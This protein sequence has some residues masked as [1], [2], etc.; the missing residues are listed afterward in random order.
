MKKLI[1]ILSVLFCTQAWSEG[2]VFQKTADVPMDVAYKR[3]YQQLEENRFYVVFEPNIGSNIS[4]FAE[5]WGEDYNRNGLTGIRSMVFC[6]GWYANAVGNA[7]PSMLAL[8]PLHVTLTE[9][10]GKTTVLF[11]R[12]TV[13]AAGSPALEVASEI[14]SQVIN[15]LEQA[16]LMPV[17]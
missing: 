4:G 13:I 8:C 10:G 1:V 9:K 5:R 7:D 16:L 14:E 2:S 11:I 17:K 12:P 15:A 6:N 3:V